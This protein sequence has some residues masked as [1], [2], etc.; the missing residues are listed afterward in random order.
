VTI[1]NAWAEG[2]PEILTVMALHRVLTS[3]KQPK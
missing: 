3:K 2:D 1:D